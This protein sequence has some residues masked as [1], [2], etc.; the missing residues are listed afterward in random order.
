MRNGAFFFFVAPALTPSLCT[1]GPGETR[2]VSQYSVQFLPKPPNARYYSCSVA[3]EGNSAELFFIAVSFAN[4]ES[5]SKSISERII[6]HQFIGITATSGYF[7]VNY[8][9]A[10]TVK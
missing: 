6:C 1:L 8:Q 7:K 3:E 10:M 5:D 4:F 9:N 2:S